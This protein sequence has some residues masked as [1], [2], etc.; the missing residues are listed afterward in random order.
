VDDV[1]TSGATVLSAARTLKAAEPASI[2]VLAVAVADPKGRS[3][4]FI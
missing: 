4:E 3:Y 2:S 1:M